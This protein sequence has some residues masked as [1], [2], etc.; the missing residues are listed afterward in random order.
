MYGKKSL[1]I[2]KHSFLLFIVGFFAEIRNASNAFLAEISLSCD[3]IVH[4]TSKS[5]P[6]CASTR[7]LPNDDIGLFRLLLA[8]C[9]LMRTLSVLPVSPTY[10]A[11]HVKHSI[12]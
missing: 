10:S 1:V 11:P 6:P 7:C 8:R 12:W 4:F 2:D 3:K 9:Y 5:S